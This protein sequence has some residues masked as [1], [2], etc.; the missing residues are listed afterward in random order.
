MA[1]IPEEPDEIR[2][3]TLIEEMGHTDPSISAPTV[4]KRL[5]EF[6]ENRI[7]RRTVKSH[8]NV[9]YQRVKS[10]FE[11]LM[12]KMEENLDQ[13]IQEGIVSPVKHTYEVELSNLLRESENSH[14]SAH[15]REKASKEFKEKLKDYRLTDRSKENLR[16]AINCARVIHEVLFRML[17]AQEFLLG[18][19][20]Y[21]RISEKDGILR[22]EFRRAK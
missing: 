7:V 8:K 13:I 10:T 19:N 17:P 3:K 21:I 5:D 16:K 22:L 9:F 12:L 14:A 2:M 11:F 15:E 4:C 6:V 20:P 1:A 18:G